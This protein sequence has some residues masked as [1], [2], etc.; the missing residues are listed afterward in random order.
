MATGGAAGP[1]E[2]GLA[3]YS[4][5]NLRIIM[6]EASRLHMKVAAH[7]LSREGISSC[8]DAGIHTIEHGADIPVEKIAAMK[9]KGI[10][11]VPTLW[12]YK[13][14]AESKGIVDEYMSR[15][16]FDIVQQQKVTFRHALK[17]GIR[18]ALGTDAG[19]PNFGP[20]PRVF[21]EMYVMNEYGMDASEVARAATIVPA[22]V[23][24]I[25]ACKGSIEEGKDGDVLLLSGNPLCDLHIF[26][27]GLEAVYQQGRLVPPAL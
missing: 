27:T 14:L 21:G 16:A 18:I 2:V 24:G 20:H 12:V 17:S 9:A 4:E 7:A 22:E 13:V 19:S 3:M 23:L 6:A 11:L 25:D 5:E 8:I 1:E 26:E 15:K 10:T